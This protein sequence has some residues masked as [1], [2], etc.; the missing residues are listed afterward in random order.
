MRV[1][2]ERVN[3]ASSKKNIVVIQCLFRNF[4]TSKQVN[5]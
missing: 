1:K 5:F 3:E 2:R 4:L